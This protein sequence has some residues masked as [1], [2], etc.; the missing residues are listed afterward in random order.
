M[1]L[2]L[3]YQF[4]SWN[5]TPVRGLIQPD[6]RFNEGRLTFTCTPHLSTNNR[7]AVIRW[8]YVGGS[9]SMCFRWGCEHHGRELLCFQMTL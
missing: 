6:S 5:H 7:G 1:T 2:Q 9:S 4:K 3:L 8:E